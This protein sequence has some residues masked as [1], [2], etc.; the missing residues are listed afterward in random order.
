MLPRLPAVLCY[1]ACLLSCATP[2]ACCPV[3]LRLPAVLC[4]P[5]CLLSCAT[6]PACCPVLPRLPAVLC[7]PAGM[8]MHNYDFQTLKVVF[9]LM[10]DH[11]P[12]R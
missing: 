7:Y 11:Y 2:P 6:P 8:T 5:A 4:Y 1:P 3:L 10:Q 9:Q 12:E